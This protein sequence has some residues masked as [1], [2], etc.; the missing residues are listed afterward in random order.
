[1]VWSISESRT[2]RQC[3]RRWYFKN[4]VA[5]AIAKK[6]PERREAYLLSKLQS[7]SAW[8]GNLVD[9]VITETLVPALNSRRTV[10]LSELKRQA[11]HYF[12]TQLACAR[13]HRLREANLKIKDS[14][15]DFAAFYCMEYGGVI[16]EDEIV[17][18]WD[19]TCKALE[20]LVQMK[21]LSSEIK[22]ARYLVSQRALQFKHSGMSVRAVPDLIAFFDDAPPLIVDWKVHFFGAQEAWLQLSAYAVALTRCSPHRDFPQSLAKWKETDIRL[23]E[24][25]LLTNQLRRF[26][27]TSDDIDNVDAYI[28]DSVTQILLATEGRKPIELHPDDFPVTNSPE[29]CQ[30]CPFRSLC[31]REPQ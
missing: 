26:A 27:L 5:N 23:A 30:R 15:D 22:A 17:R 9:L 31:W 18:A 7:I 21:E 4:C 13:Q 12:D 24:A 1:M 28:A 14:G 25:Q 16:P 3:P 6:D 8:R 19:E 2:F 11:K 29:A 20:N 10:M